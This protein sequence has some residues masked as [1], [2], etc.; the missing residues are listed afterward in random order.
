MLVFFRFGNVF[1]EV[2]I[3]VPSMLFLLEDV[4]S[5]YE[6]SKKGVISTSFMMHSFKSD[7]ILLS[8]YP[9]TIGDV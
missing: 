6:T 2:Y 7:M 1:G 4:Y 3:K 8:F 9:V 5:V